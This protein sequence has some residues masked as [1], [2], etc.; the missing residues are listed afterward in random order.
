MSYMQAACFIPFGSFY[1]VLRESELT[2]RART[3]LQPV[4]LERVFVMS[5]QQLAQKRKYM[6]MLLLFIEEVRLSSSK[7]ADIPSSACVSHV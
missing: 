2:V 5:P 4:S 1:S 3:A 6:V 7:S